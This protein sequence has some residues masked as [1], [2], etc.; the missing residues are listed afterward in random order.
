[1]VPATSVWGE[2]ILFSVNGHYYEIVRGYYSWTEANALA[3][4]MTYKGMQGY[5]ATITSEEEQWFIYNN[6]LSAP[7]FVE[8]VRPGAWLGGS[9]ANEE[10]VWRWVTGP[11]GLEN[12]GLGRLLSDGYT[13]WAGGEPNDEDVPADEDYLMMWSYAGDGINYFPGH[14][15]ASGWND[16]QDEWWSTFQD[17]AF[18]VEYGGLESVPE[19]ATVLLLSTALAGLGILR[20]RR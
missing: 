18:I 2:P 10:G 7:P 4:G 9:D 12:G 5:L 17:A 14:F 11:E 15:A 16:A 19:P 1:L 8:Q 13:H 6:F 20:K 3:Q